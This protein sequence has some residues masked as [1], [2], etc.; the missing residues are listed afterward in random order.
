MGKA[1]VRFDCKRRANKD[2]E[3]RLEEIVEIA[4]SNGCYRSPHALSLSLNKV[5]LNLK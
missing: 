4:L 1:Q 3:T 2:K 5:G